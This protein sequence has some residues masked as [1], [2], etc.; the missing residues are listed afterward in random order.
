[1][2]APGIVNFFHAMLSTDAHNLSRKIYLIMRRSNARAQLHD[3]ISWRRTKPRRHQVNRSPGNSQLTPLP[4]RMHQTE[5]A[6]DRINKV[7][8][9]TIGHVDSEAHV[10]LIRNQTIAG[11]E[12]LVGRGRTIDHC[13]L[14]AVHLLGGHEWHR[15]ESVFR[16]DVSMDRIESTQRL[17]LVMPHIDSRDAVDKNVHAPRRSGKRGKVLDRQ[18]TIRVGHGDA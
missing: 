11:G 13:H 2:H 1:M 9:A 7:N 3:Q 5:D 12:T 4:A 8:R 10:G 17:R 18:R 6:A 14:R 16:A 15:P